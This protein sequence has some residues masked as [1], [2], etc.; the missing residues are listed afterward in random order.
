MASNAKWRSRLIEA[1]KKGEM[2]FWNH[3]KGFLDPLDAL[4]LEAKYGPRAVDPPAPAPAPKA[5]KPS[6]ARPPAKKSSKK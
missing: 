2:L 6:K 3:N 5:K 4:T 1:L